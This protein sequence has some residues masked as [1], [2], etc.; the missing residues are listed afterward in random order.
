MGK[1][2]PKLIPP[3]EFRRLLTGIEAIL[4]EKY[5]K[6]KLPANPRT[7]TFTY[8]SLVQAR[9]ILVD[10]FLA[11][12]MEI[13]LKDVS[14]TLNVYRVHTFP[15]MRPGTNITVRYEVEGKYLALVG[16]A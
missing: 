7:E 12:S 4:G 3:R 14:R 1:L 11:V 5:P 13:P 16:M 6:L 8:Y 15:L 2:T 10:D 9:P